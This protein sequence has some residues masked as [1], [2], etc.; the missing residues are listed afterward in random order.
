MFPRILRG[1]LT[2]KSVVVFRTPDAKDDDVDAGS[3]M[4]AR[5]PARWA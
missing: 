2:G 1:A 3:R 4:V 5:S